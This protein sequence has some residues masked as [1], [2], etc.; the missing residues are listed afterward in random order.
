M[1]R[2]SPVRMDS[3][4]EEWPS[5]IFPSVGIVSPGRTR[6]CWPGWISAQGIIFSV[7][8]LRRRAVGGVR[9][10]RFFRDW[11]S[12]FSE[13]CSSHWP[14]RTRVVMAAAASKNRELWERGRKSVVNRL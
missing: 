12:L 3:S 7:V 9:L 14:A 2:G 13:Y 11:A 10:R 1:G 8:P 5:R 4:T 6:R